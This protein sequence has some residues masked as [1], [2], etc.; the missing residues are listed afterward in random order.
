[1]VSRMKRFG[2]LSLNDASPVKGHSAGLL[3]E[4]NLPSRIYLGGYPGGHYH[5]ES[6]VTS[7]LH[8]AIQRVGICQSICF[9]QLDIDMLQVWSF[10]SPNGY[11]MF[12]YDGYQSVDNLVYK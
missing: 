2:M 10:V 6:G 9:G 12:C 4:L 3:T 11:C 1:V 5:P 8:G 7:G